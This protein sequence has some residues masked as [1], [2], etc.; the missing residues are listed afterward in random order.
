MGNCACA[1]L[2]SSFR[3][4]ILTGRTTASTT[5][6][7]GGA[8]AF[9]KHAAEFG[10]NRNA[11]QLTD[12]PLRET[13]R[14]ARRPQCRCA[15]PNDAA[16]A[17]AH[18]TC[19]HTPSGGPASASVISS[20]RIGSPRRQETPAAAQFVADVA[21]RRFCQHLRVVVA[22]LTDDLAVI[23]VVAG[24]AISGWD[25]ADGTGMTPLRVT[26][27]AGRAGCRAGV[28]VAPSAARTWGS[29]RR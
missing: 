15:G 2:S 29:D 22:F 3:R 1:G 8:T 11:D 19:A 5:W 6:P 20:S 18:R 17:A 16:T 27:T 12:Y 13:R 25:C 9:G 4:G 21:R 26:A 10:G 23:R 7:P 24:G 14:P 28:R